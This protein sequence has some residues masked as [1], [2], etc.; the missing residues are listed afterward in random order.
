MKKR[1]AEKLEEKR[2]FWQEH[3][4]CL[5]K[6]GLTQVEYCRQN[7]LNVKHVCYWKKK[8][9]KQVCQVALVEIPTHPVKSICK[10]WNAISPIRMT[11]NG[12]FAF[13]IEKGFDPLTLRQTLQ[14]VESL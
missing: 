3:I 9:S 4:K 11:V 1:Y 2:R 6:S 13:E 12:R 14:V 10:T 8:F 7:N 5:E